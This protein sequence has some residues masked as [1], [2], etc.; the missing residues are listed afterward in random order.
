MLKLRN[1]HG[2]TLVEL[3]V[4]IAIIGILI[5]LLLP[6]VQAAREAARRM[7][8]TNNMKQFGL[9]IHCFLDVHRK[10][11][12]AWTCEPKPLSPHPSYK[13]N[14]PPDQHT[15][16][17]QIL[18]FMEQ[19]VLKELF[20]FEYRTLDD[21]NREATN[22]EITSYQCP[23]DDAQG[24]KI[25]AGLSGDRYYS[26]SNYAV[27]L[28]SNT[29]VINSGGTIASLAAMG[30]T[31]NPNITL[32]ND[33]AFCPC[34]NK[35]IA[36]L[37]DGTSHIVLASE[38]RAGQADG[39]STGWD[40]RGWW[41][42]PNM[43]GC[44]YTH[45]TT[46]NTTIADLMYPSECPPDPPNDMPCTVNGGSQDEHFAAA[47]SRH[48]GGVNALFGDGHVSFFNDDIDA[49]VWQWLGS[50]KDGNTITIEH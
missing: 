6:A 49:T 30:K 20:N 13:N 4:V 12:T 1:K 35:K 15:V 14:S 31:F 34:E 33:G 32:D 37:T 25:I 38:V 28:G 26:R 7:Q 42:W 39:G 45:L 48:P 43:G 40:T 10:L 29:M 11:P 44:I 18:P 19:D 36:D 23:S 5:A 2:F 21:M 9:A 24:R 17:A 22:H 16:F 50:I 46:P 27:C 41:S 8:C 47:R 3:L